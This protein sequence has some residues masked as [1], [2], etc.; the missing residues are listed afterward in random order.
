MKLKWAGVNPNAIPNPDGWPESGRLCVVKRNGAPFLAVARIADD[1]DDEFSR[2]CL[3]WVITLFPAGIHT[4]LAEQ[5]DE[6]AY[7]GDEEN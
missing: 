7:L 4:L 2:D 1:L 5:D 6:W 3:S